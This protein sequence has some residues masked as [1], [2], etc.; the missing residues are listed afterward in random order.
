MSFMSELDAEQ[1]GNNNYAAWSTK[2]KQN[3]RIAAEIEGRNTAYPFATIERYCGYEYRQINNYLR[4]CFDDELFAV[5]KEMSHILTM[6]ICDAPTISNNIVVYRMACDEF[7][8]HLY[9]Q[10][11]NG[12]PAVEKGFMSTGLLENIAEQSDPYA[13]HK[14]I[15]KIYVPKGTPGIYVNSIAKRSEQE[16]LIAPNRFLGMINYPHVEKNGKTMIE[17]KLLNMETSLALSMV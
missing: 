1:W 9:Q 14:H 10:N 16:I 13:E 17:C 3:M 5:Y 4:G 6:L 2:Y 7:I 15:L 12:K 11:K 8:D